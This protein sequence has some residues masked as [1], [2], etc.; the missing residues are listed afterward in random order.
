MHV[1]GVYMDVEGRE[2]GDQ[3]DTRT[4]DCGCGEKFT[5][6]KRWQR[7]LSDQHRDTYHNRRRPKKSSEK[8]QVI[9]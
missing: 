2:M 3:S 8:K 5:P 7:F 4:C 1:D 6:R 9:P